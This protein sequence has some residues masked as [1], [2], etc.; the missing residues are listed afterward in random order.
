MTTTKS[1]D[2]RI[3]D[4]QIEFESHEYRSPIKFGGNVVRDVV[5]LNV[6]LS[7]ENRAGQVATGLGSMPLGNVWA[8]PPIRVSPS[9]SLAAMRE[10]AHHE[11]D[12]TRAFDQC[13]HPLDMSL[14]LESKFLEAAQQLGQ[15]VNL[16]E[17][18]PK[19][20]ALVVSSPFDAALFDGFGKA[21]GIHAF[22][23]L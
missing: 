16:A 15:S 14:Q 3:K 20:A 10:L 19:L 1:T 6:Q 23:G 12:I 21:A 17:P 22:H 13:A 4:V 11:A 9:E 7:V 2:I 8:F 18:V 5:L